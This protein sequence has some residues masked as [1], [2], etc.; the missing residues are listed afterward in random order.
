MLDE[1][2]PS[3]AYNILMEINTEDLSLSQIGESLR[4]TPRI[5]YTMSP[6]ISNL[7]P[8]DVTNDPVANRSRIRYPYASAIS[9]G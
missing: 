1:H 3:T 6:V 2:G 8:S 7:P 9:S 4:I 5:D